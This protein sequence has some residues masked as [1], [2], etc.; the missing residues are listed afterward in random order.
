LAASAFAEPAK[1]ASNEET[2][3]REVVPGEDAALYSCRKSPA[4]V[5]V[6]FKKET[7]VSELVTWAMGFT[8]KKFLL[9]PRIVSTQRKVTLAAPMQMT[10]QEAYRL[11]LAALKTIGLAV[12]VEGDR[13]T[14][15]DAKAIK[16]EHVPLVRSVD[17]ADEVIRYVLRPSYTTPAVLKQAFD[18]L[19]SEAG[20]IQVV[21][22]FVLVVDHGNHVRDMIAFAKL[23]DVPNGSDG[24]YTIPV[25]HADA[26]KLAEKVNQLFGA[27]SVAATA[28]GAPK[29]GGANAPAPP[30][31]IVDERTN[32]LV[33]AASQAVFERVQAFVKRIDIELGLDDGTSLHVYRLRAAIAEEVAK[34]LSDAIQ[35]GQQAAT[36]QRP[37]APPQTVAPI[38]R[39]ASSLEGTVKVTA[40]KGTNKLIIMSSGRDFLALREII[41]EIDQPRREVYI[42][43][44]ILEV[45]VENDSDIG[46]GSHIGSPL[47][48]GG[49][50]VG[51]VQLPDLGTT[52]PSALSKAQ[53][54]VGALIGAP[55]STA[56]TSALGLGTSLPSYTVL[57]KALAQT[58][59]SHV[60]SAPSVI[61]VDNEEAV[62]KIG[63]NIPYTKGQIPTI[64][65]TPSVV[66][67]NVDRMPLTLDLKIK[68]H[69]SADE[70]ILLEVAHSAKDA[71]DPDPNLGPI[72]SERSI[73]TRVVVRDQQT[74]VL[75]G[76]MQEHYDT[77]VD[78]VPVLGDI[79]VLGN[80]FR[81]TI[82]KKVK[83][84]I[85]VLL[86]PYII[87][88]QSEI[89]AI[90]AR[91][92]RQYDELVGS[93]RALD[94]M[95][96]MPKID[97]RR[98][99]GLVEE[100]NRTVVAVDE[101]RAERAALERTRT[102]VESGSVL[103]AE[104]PAPR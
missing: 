50:G 73:E 87:R 102:R 13:L 28:G 34:T 30:K 94:A 72:W 64:P 4:A 78:K 26:T 45:S 10:P 65:G 36:T 85:V 70:T 56:I 53:G 100:I 60:V 84:N 71:L 90:R 79:P 58:K 93:F 24:I 95:T 62:Y 88:D 74:V 55:V 16:G 81:H 54:A 49:L 57:F 11:F 40:D 86:T 92:V 91:E 77:I 38:D 51:G 99:R 44:L 43:A 23:V 1:R 48:G 98:K 63:R 52:D 61:A 31:I 67:S 41:R 3:K 89:E 15:A 82:K 75:G 29:P 6:T 21:G 47:T 103:P 32:T 12:V 69:I 25:L 35:K 14:I 27:S 76:L 66:Q 97:Y 83:S 80:L 7:D 59:N 20:D 18:A 104:P 96:Y 17:G 33:V 2:G 9:D 46:A 8:C 68:P 22:A 39:V 37:G 5:M 101:D 19:R 42:E